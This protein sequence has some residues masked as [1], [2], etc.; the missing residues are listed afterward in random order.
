MIKAGIMVDRFDISQLGIYMGSNLHAL[1]KERSDIDYVVF[2]KNWAKPP[3]YPN[4]C[5]LME[6]EIWGFNG[7]IIATS[8]STAQKLIN[9]P[10][11][12]RKYFYVWNLEWFMQNT[13]LYEDLCKIFKNPHIDL[14]ARSES[15]SKIIE[16][17]WKKPAL[18]MEDFDR[19][20]LAEIATC[21]SHTKN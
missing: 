4:F 3:V 7:P 17:V 19:T 11:S 13:L 21:A 1:M 20:V 8:I 18:I 16:K 9:C 14:V 12:P 2:Y 5:M 15:H 10:G 6:R